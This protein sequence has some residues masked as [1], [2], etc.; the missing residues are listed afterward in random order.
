MTNTCATCRWWEPIS[1][2]DGVIRDGECRR[3][4]PRPILQPN[5]TRRRAFYAET[6]PEDWCGE[7]EPQPLD[8]PTSPA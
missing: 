5:V 3:Y 2:L 6:L 8:A 1:D 4:A 7:H